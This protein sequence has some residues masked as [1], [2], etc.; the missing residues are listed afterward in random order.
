MRRRPGPRHRGPGAVARRALRDGPPRQRAGRTGRW[1][2]RP[3]RRGRWSIGATGHRGERRDRPFARRAARSVTPCARLAGYRGD[4][5]AGWRAAVGRTGTPTRCLRGL[6]DGPRRQR[7]P[8]IGAHCDIPVVE[9]GGRPCT[10]P[11]RTGASLRLGS[12]AC[13]AFGRSRSRPRHRPSGPAAARP[14]YARAC[15]RGMVGAGAADGRPSASGAR[16]A[17]GAPCRAAPAPGFGPAVRVRPRP[18]TA[19]LDRIRHPSR[20]EP[21]AVGAP[22]YGEPRLGPTPAASRSTR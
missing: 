20:T 9:G 13:L 8:P 21:G 1:E 11:S 15:T 5:G 18:P 2:A 12:V 17:S 10:A 6:V 16:G 22:R 4:A 3:S 7:V 19:G 14:A